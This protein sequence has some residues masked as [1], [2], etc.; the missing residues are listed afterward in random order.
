MTC[1]E[2]EN[3]ILLD[4]AGLLADEPDVL[5]ALRAHLAT[6]CPVC[7]GH[8]AESDAMIAGIARTVTPVAP[9]QRMWD[10]LAGRMAAEREQAAGA[11]GDAA[12]GGGSGSAVVAGGA[13]PSGDK[14]SADASVG[15]GPPAHGHPAATDDT[16]TDFAG[17]DANAGPMRIDGSVSDGQSVAADGGSVATDGRGDRD[18][19]TAPAGRDRPAGER[20]RPAGGSTWRPWLG[21]A[22]AAVLGAAVTLGVVWNKLQDQ[23]RLLRSGDVQLVSL[24]GQAAQPTARGRIFWDQPKRQWHVFVFDLK[25]PA[26]G[27]TYELWFITKD[28]KKIKAGLFDTDSTGSGSLVVALPQY[29]GQVVTAAV[30]DE[31]TGGSAQPTGQMQLVG[32][33]NPAGK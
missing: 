25:P 13:H 11:V 24:D 20:S 21:A 17:T 31:P 6:G 19:A 7:A 2:R 1:N 14:D 3:L 5:A 23:G 4:A 8:L 9:P 16:V 26:P 12:A 33:I 29:L 15:T 27:K 10:A 32:A 28:Q 18:P 22:V 30:T